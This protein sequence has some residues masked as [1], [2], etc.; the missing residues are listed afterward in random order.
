MIYYRFFYLNPLVLV[1]H[2]LSM[3]FLSCKKCHNKSYY[4]KLCPGFAL[5]QWA[6]YKRTFC[7]HGKCYLDASDIV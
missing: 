4:K 5:F 2:K 1:Y 3:V 7:R 6:F